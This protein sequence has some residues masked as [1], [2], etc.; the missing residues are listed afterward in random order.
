MVDEF[1]TLVCAGVP[2]TVWTGRTV[3]AGL[4]VAG[5]AVGA[6]DGAVVVGTT[7]TRLSVAEGAAAGE[8]PTTAVAGGSML[9]G[10][11]PP[12]GAS[13]SL[14]SDW[15]AVRVTTATRNTRTARETDLVLDVTTP[16]AGWSPGPAARAHWGRWGGLFGSVVSYNVTKCDMGRF[17]CRSDVSVGV[18]RAKRSHVVQEARTTL[19]AT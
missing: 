12:A 4:D 1:G 11:G 8:V 17:M 5:G 14:W 15:H 18:L 3:G 19:G 10:A 13:D 9:A 7:A 6:D 16:P 2:E